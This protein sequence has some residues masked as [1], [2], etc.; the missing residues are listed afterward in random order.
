MILALGTPQRGQTMPELD[1]LAIE[2]SPYS[3]LDCR[4]PEKDTR[5]RPTYRPDGRIVI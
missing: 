3:L 1:R 4:N 5:S 2:I